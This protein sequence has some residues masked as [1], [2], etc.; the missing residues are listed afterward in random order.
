MAETTISRTEF[1]GGPDDAERKL[2]V[3]ERTDGSAHLSIST[4][5]KQVG[6]R[7]T[8]ELRQRVADILWGNT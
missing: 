5:T 7:L 1:E 8:P 3:I 6:F 2:I 4:H